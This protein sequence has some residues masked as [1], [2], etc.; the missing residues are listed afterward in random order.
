MEKTNDIPELAARIA[1]TVRGVMLD[2]RPRLIEAT[3]H[4]H[5]LNKAAE[6]DPDPAGPQPL[7]WLLASTPD[8]TT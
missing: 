2:L 5:F 7:T 6:Y 8:V 3:V 4:R 1:E